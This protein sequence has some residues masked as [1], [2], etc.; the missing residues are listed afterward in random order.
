MD[1]YLTKPA[2]LDALRGAIV[3]AASMRA[4]AHD[5]KRP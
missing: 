1:E 5:G 4:R 3:R 2:S